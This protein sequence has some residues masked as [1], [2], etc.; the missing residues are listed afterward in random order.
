MKV[1][2]LLLQYM[3]YYFASNSC[4]CAVQSKFDICTT[5]SSSHIPVSAILEAQGASLPLWANT[6]V[7]LLFLLIFRILGYIVLR[8]FRRPKWR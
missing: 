7:L 6:L 1:N 4:R 8:Y 2:V 3:K 5:N